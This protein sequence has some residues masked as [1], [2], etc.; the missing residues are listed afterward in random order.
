VL[1]VDDE[2][3]AAVLA[4]ASAAPTPVGAEVIS[5]AKHGDRAVVI[6]SNNSAPAI[7]AYL[8]AQG[9]LDDV[10]GVAGRRRGSPTL[11]KSNPA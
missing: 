11:M 2:L 8:A 5:A 4:A 6:V 3:R 7:R 1:A 9:L 10:A